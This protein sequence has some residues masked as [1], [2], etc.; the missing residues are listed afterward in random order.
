LSQDLSHLAADVL[1]RLVSDLNKMC[2]SIVNN[3]I[4]PALRDANSA[5]FRHLNSINEN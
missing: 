2:G 5:D 4:R 3:D 1:L